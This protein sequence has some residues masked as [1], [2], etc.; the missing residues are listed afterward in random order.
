MLLTLLCLHSHHHTYREA[1]HGLQA[2]RWVLYKSIAHFMAI[3]CWDT[4]FHSIDHVPG[5][6]VTCFHTSINS[7]NPQNERMRW[8][9]ILPRL[10]RREHWG[11]ERLS[12]QPEVTQQVGGEPTVLESALFTITLHCPTPCCPG[13]R[14]D[15]QQCSIN[16]SFTGRQFLSSL[17]G[18]MFQTASLLPTIEFPIRDLRFVASSVSG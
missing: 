6:L 17:F 5:M 2:L 14:V 15:T 4:A 1:T 18:F 7:F 11:T 12:H 16:T 9:L 3:T 10:Y 13:H 8:A